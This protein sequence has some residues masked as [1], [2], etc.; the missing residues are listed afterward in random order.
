MTNSTKPQSSDFVVKF[1]DTLAA[2][3]DDAPKSQKKD[4]DVLLNEFEAW[5]TKNGIVMD[6]LRCS[7]R[8]NMNC[9]TATREIQPD[10][11]VLEVPRAAMITEEDAFEST[12]GKYQRRNI[13]S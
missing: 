6:G 1:H 9:L 3:L 11:V 12:L 13:S 10:E 4:Y 5:A 7:R 8:D 2:A